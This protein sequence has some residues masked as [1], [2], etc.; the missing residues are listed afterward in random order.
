MG[1]GF[2]LEAF[3]IAGS[4]MALFAAGRWFLVKG[5]YKEY[6]EKYM[7]ADLIFCTVFALSCNMLELVI[8]EIVP[9]LGTK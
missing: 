7:A 5:V 8:L 2:L 1:W 6:E 9:V 4:L 3:V